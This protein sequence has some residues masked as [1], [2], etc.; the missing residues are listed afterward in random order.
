MISHAKKKG[1]SSLMMNIMNP[2][3]EINQADEHSKQLSSVF[4]S[5]VLSGIINILGYA[6]P[7]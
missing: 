3:K 2:W 1:L 7:Y 6:T 5:C 4:K